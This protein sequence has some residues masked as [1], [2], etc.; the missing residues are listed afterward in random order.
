MGIPGERL[1][2]KV[3]EEK[4]RGHKIWFSFSTG[5]MFD[6]TYQVRTDAITDLVKQKSKKEEAEHGHDGLVEKVV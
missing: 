3:F 4:L 1:T 5:R 2:E 6:P